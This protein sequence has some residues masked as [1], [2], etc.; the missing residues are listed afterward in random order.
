MRSLTAA[1]ETLEG[2]RFFGRVAGVQ[3]LNV[4]IAGLNPVL[5]VGAR[6][7]VPRQNG[8][9][10]VCEVVGFRDEHAICLP[11]GPLEGVR[12]G[13]PAALVASAGTAWPD[14]PWLGRVIDAM[15]EP[16]D[17]GPPLPRGPRPRPLKA[18]A[19]PAHQR[20][21]VGEKLDLGIRALNTFASCCLGQRLGIFAG[22]GVGKSVLMSMLARYTASDV[23]VIALI[24]E[25]G[26]EVKEFLEDD[27]GPEG[28]ARSVVVVAT[29]D[30]PALKRRQAAYLAMTLAEHF[31]DEG[32]SVLLMMDSVTRFAMAQ[33]EIGLAAGEPPT[34]K[35]YTPTVFAELPRLLERAGPGRPGSGSI[36]GLFTVLVDA[37]DHNEPIADA[38]RGILDGH[39]VME[40]AIAERGR[41]PAINVLKSVSRTMPACNSDEETTLVREARTLMA[42]YANMEELIR[43]GA[44]RKGSDAEVDRAIRA[45]DALESFLAQGRGERASLAEGY[46][47]LAEILAS[48]EAT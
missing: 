32:K 33:R 13:A 31:R 38:V 17:G 42:T 14:D 10:T 28:L 9:A 29:S 45:A 20:G 47:Q 11:Y 46:R 27:L 26:R 21:R 44:Y 37:D 41:Y 35:G 7:S 34:T 2:A 19:L 30:E 22:S 18:I 8:G 6:L 40:R 23:N 1:I 43:V 4:D 48:V 5:A 39:V 16:I 12:M 36:T 3:G 24:G 25:R 15:G